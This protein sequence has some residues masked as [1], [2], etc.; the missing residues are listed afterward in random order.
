MGDKFKYRLSKN[1]K[2]EIAKNLIDIIEKDSDISKQ[3]RNFIINW[4]STDASGKRKAFFDV[5]DLVLKNYLPATRPV[6][7]RAC[8]RL[9]KNGKIASFTGRWGCARQFSNCKGALIVCDTEETPPYK[10]S[11]E[12]KHSFYPLGSVL[13]KAKTKGGCGFTKQFLDR[14]IGEDEYIMRVNFGRMC[15]FRWSR[16]L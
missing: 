9:S 2:E 1:Q 13:E 10:K 6:L 12:Y 8:D 15:C 14:Y 5:W 7:F 4:C 11:G 3:T 16:N